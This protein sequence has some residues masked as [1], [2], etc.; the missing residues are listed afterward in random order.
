MDPLADLG[1]N[2]PCW[3]GSQRKYKF[4]HGNK[5]PASAPGAALPTDAPGT[6]YISPTVSVDLDALTGSLRAGTPIT[7]P[8]PEPTPHSIPYTNWEQDLP[9]AVL[10]PS[11]PM[12]PASL[13]RL[14]V[15]VLRHISRKRNGE[16]PPSDEV[17]EA[18]YRLAGE[19]IKTVDSLSREQPKLT[20]LWNEE[21]DVSVFIG[22]TLLLADHVLVPDNI[23]SAIQRS[24]DMA[25]IGR[26]AREQLVHADLIAS[27]AAIPVPNGVAMAH[28]GPAAQRLTADDL[29]N[30]R[31]VAWVRDQL[32]FEG[33]TARE[34]LLVS[35]GDDLSTKPA[36]F[37]MYGR[38][39]P[40]SLTSKPD[41][42]RSACC[43]HT[44]PVT[45][46]RGG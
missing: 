8:P 43:S 26:H 15:D 32:I 23:F 27:G 33:P 28:R 12:D 46:T 38:I 19:T 40:E 5:R 7:L 29:S 1:R 22:R 9:S 14:R 11:E 35:A 20:V 18:L 42:S 3:C 41:F 44:S 30:E 36:Q 6:R 34:A 21:L 16:E 4:C 25:A 31:L 39:V 10:D 37:W 17:L 13:G 45:T 2:E 24:A